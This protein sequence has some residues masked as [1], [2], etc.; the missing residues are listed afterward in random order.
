M[1]KSETELLL[2][3]E[4]L[5]AENRKLEALFRTTGSEE[6]FH[7][8]FRNH[9]A[10]MLLVHPGSGAIVEA[11]KAAESFYGYAFDG[12]ENISI[13]TLNT[14][15][16]DLV[17]K[18]MEEAFAQHRNYFIFPHRLASGE[19]RT[20]KVHSS[21]IELGGQ[22][23]LFS[24][25]HDITERKKAEHALQWN[26]SLLQKMNSASPLAFLVVDNRNDAIL[27]FNHQFCEIWGIVHLEEQMLRGEL[28]NNDIIPDCLAVLK[29]IPSFAQSC[30]PLQDEHNQVVLE[31]EIPFI[32][33]RTIRRFSAQIRG[34]QNEYFG[35]LY[36]FE[37][38]T[39]R[40]TTEQFIRIQRDLAARHNAMTSLPEALSWALEAL[41]QFE[42][43]DCGGIYLLNAATGCLELMAHQGLSDDFVGRTAR[44]GPDDIRTRMV[45]KGT[46]QYIS[47][48]E[49]GDPEQVVPDS[50]GIFSLAILPLQHEGEI[51]GCINLASKTSTE[52]SRN[53][54]F[55]LEALA[56]QIG[57]T[58]SRIRAE[59]SLKQSQKNFQSLFDT[60]DDFMF[61]LDVEGRMIRT[62]PVVKRRLGYS[63]EELYLKHVLEV[64]PPSRREE[65]GFIVNEMLANR[66]LFCPVPLITKE[67]VQIPVE[68]RVVLGK[69]DDQD[70]L[71]GISRDITERLKAEEELQRRESYLS[72]VISNHPGM[73]WMKDLQGKFLLMND[74]NDAFLKISGM[75]DTRQVIGMTDFDFMPGELARSYKEEDNYVMKTRLPM[76]KEEQGIIDKHEA[77]FEKYKFPVVDKTGE[78]IGVSAYSIDITERKIAESAL[79]M[80][81]AAFESFALPIVI[82]DPEGC[83]TWANTSFLNLTGYTEEEIIGRTNGM[84]V[85]S[86][87]QD[88]AFY[89]ALWNTVRSGK[90]WSGELINRRK[91]G[92]QYP[93]ELTITPVFAQGNKIS[94]YI[95][96][97]I[98]LT[99]KKVM[100]RALR[101]SE[102]RWNFALEGSG[103]G[104]WD[105][106]M[107]TNNVFFSK[108]WKEMLGYDDAG[109]YMLRD[110]QK[111]VHP[112]DKKERKADLEKHFRGETEVYMNEHRVLCRDGEYKWVFDRGKIVS[113]D[114]DGK[115]SRIIGTYTDITGRKL[116]EQTLR[117]GIAREKELNELKSKFVSV[118]SHEFRTP[119]ATILAISE[120]LSAYGD[121][122]TKEQQQLR[123]GRIRV[124]VAHLNKIIEEILHL[125]K[126]QAKEVALEPE[127]FDIAALFIDIVE[128]FR[129]Q[130]GLGGRLVFQPP[131]ASI[132]VTLDKNQVSLVL[133]NLLT[134][135]FKY[136]GPED[137]VT[138]VVVPGPGRVVFTVEDKGIGIPD[139]DLRHL[140]KPFYR[141]SNT[142]HISGTGLGLNIIMESVTRHGGTIDV[143]SEV[144]KGTIFT[145]ILPEAIPEE[146]LTRP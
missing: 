34:E 66:A 23:L 62:N 127:Y 138:L 56:M 63:D 83:V 123:L 13:H 19:K 10:V 85:K 106:N 59:T 146:K 53:I 92:T 22:Q 118:A 140:F 25:I 93:E 20:V 41:L 15:P 74:R 69:W 88:K 35:R 116:L 81:S 120:S 94:S 67:G 12:K 71:F 111:W 87:Q 65:A 55:T 32:D 68:T 115:P 139:D 61:I 142:G 136:S 126:L 130:R 17:R 128:G 72:A 78:V 112:E 16:G 144:N 29:D 82:T 91:N 137:P 97:S 4:I 89:T 38:I 47:C 6:Q 107:K 141:A 145:V 37:D 40:K 14:L 64:H 143:D 95:A 99:E 110:W 58:I 75:E 31:D 100:E 132:P 28:K 48:S 3:I 60:L 49:L 86:G 18:E 105:W 79:K 135:A 36:I 1:K 108:Q 43:V 27:Y 77:W 121:R 50:D 45:Q 21:P 113:K 80:Q 122:M 119:L 8:M 5:K 33:G 131:A 44:Y 42:G 117:D 70:V 46:S 90:I 114:P 125:S 57:G 101:E 9:D 7:T 76:V 52:V 30:T 98:D 54:R 39:R 104:V 134:N 2:E 103:D 11:N 51:I 84:L 102:A 109:P 129:A 124:Q 133:T 73:F 96:I 26:E 24:V